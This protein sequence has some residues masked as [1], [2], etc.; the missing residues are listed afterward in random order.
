VTRASLIRRSV[1]MQPR[2][3]FR[4]RRCSKEWMTHVASGASGVA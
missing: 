4:P 3:A 1:G 2:G